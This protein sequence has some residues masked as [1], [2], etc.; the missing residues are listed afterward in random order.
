MLHPIYIAY[1]HF[2]FLSIDD[3][4]A[5]SLKTGDI[6]LFN[7][8]PLLY[9]LPAS[10]TIALRKL[11][12][13]SSSSTSSSSSYLSNKRT[14]SVPDHIGIII[15]HQGIPYVI[16]QTFSGIKAR[17]YD[18]R[19]RCSRSKEIIVRPLVHELRSEEKLLSG[20]FLQRYLSS[21][22]SSS[23][24]NNSNTS[25]IGSTDTIL[26]PWNELFRTLLTTWTRSKSIK[27]NSSSSSLYL[28]QQYYQT[29]G[30]YSRNVPTDTKPALG[31]IDCLP[32]NQP[33]QGTETL[34]SNKVIWVRDLA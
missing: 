23:G 27:E 32:N 15:L 10:I 17:R 13:S 16:E 31:I 8:D 3:I 28:L 33:L 11:A 20:Q 18:H 1:L 4:I 6:I 24:G 19:I 9:Y 2:S 26:Y 12:S 22:N 21:T 5:D 30:L 34:Y 25:V 29:I 14:S 7:R